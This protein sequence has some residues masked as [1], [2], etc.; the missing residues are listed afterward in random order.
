MTPESIPQIILDTDPGGDD[1]FALLWLLSLVKQGLADL[2]AVT[3]TEGNVAVQKTFS[4]AS[5]VLSFMG[6]S[7]IEIGRGVPIASHSGADAGHIHGADGMGNLSQTLPP[8]IHRFE[9]ARDADQLIVDRLNATPGETTIVAIGP[10]TNLA[11]AEL[12]Q[13][14]ILKKARE[15]V[16]MAGAFQCGGNVTPQAEFNVWLNPIAA[17]VV[18]DSRN[19]IVVL[20]LD[21][22]RHLIF[23][24][25]MA[26]AVTQ[27]NRNGKTAHFLAALCEFMISTA[28]QYRETG[29]NP[30][31]L[32]HDA[33]TIAYLFYPET[34]ILSRSQV[35]VE[36]QG[37]WTKGQ[38]LIDRRHRPKSNANAW[39][40]QEIDAIGFFTSLIEDLKYLI[41]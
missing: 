28:L 21:V 2:V 36:T 20:P 41:G 3:A 16:I 37:E 1:I 34:L 12:R 32:V 14:G 38:T 5:Q 13:P 26:Q 39:V 18:F 22:T 4:N 8:S 29:G 9:T 10:L 25:D 35:Q 27:T 24:Q 17:Q 31:F 40:A 6:F 30:G 33:V 19:D 15:I 7:A 11:A 23:T